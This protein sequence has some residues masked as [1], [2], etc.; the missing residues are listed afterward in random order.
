MEKEGCPFE[1]I[2]YAGL[3]ITPSGV[4]VVEFNA[5]HGDPEAEVYLPLLE[6]NLLEL[7]L[8]AMAHDGSFE[9]TPLVSSNLAAVDIVLASYGYPGSYESGYPII[10]FDE[11]QDERDNGE[12]Q[13]N[14]HTGI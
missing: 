3:M 7:M 9:R 2:L 1:G 4:K 10:G 11:I 12:Y 14:L 5:R 8:S 6:S 13:S